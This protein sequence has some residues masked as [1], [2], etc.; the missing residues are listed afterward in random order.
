MTWINW[1]AL[2]S[3]LIAVIG[4]RKLA[5]TDPITQILV[6][7]TAIALPVVVLE[8]L[9]FKRFARLRYRR[10]PFDV[11]L[12]RVSIK[13]AGLAASFGLLVVTYWVFPY[14]T[15]GDSKLV[16]DL[17]GRI[18]IPL[19]ILTPIYFWFVDG[20]MDDPEDD[21]HA[22][23]LFALG[24]LPESDQPKLANHVRACFVKIFFYQYILSVTLVHLTGM[25]SY[26][27][28]AT[29]SVAPFGFMNLFIDTVWF[30]D[31][32]F[33]CTGY[34]LTFRLFNSH[35]R[36]A[37]PTVLG[38]LVCLICY[39]T[40]YEMLTRSFLAYE[41][42]I[43]WG[44]WLGDMPALQ[45]LWAIPI[46][47]LL[48]VYALGSVQFGIRFSNLTHRGIITNGPFRLTKHPQYISKNI[49]FWFISVPFIS[50][51]GPEEAIRHCVMLAGFNFIFYLRAKTEERHLSRDPVYRAYA[52][53]IAQ[54]GLIARARRLMGFA[55]AA[56]VVPLTTTASNHPLP[57]GV[58][59][60]P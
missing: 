52:A 46:V 53:W 9:H 23:G 18:W 40:F 55:T 7:I 21:Y 59:K 6:I 44:H 35:I 13:L 17:F 14:F 58:E 56:Y 43:Y 22:A 16:Y 37:E 41:N 47:V 31:V 51:S 49:A 29:V 34:F 19:V 1:I 42:G 39:G 20:L 5:I 27:P 10:D 28:L 12:K 45:A 26:D 2:A 3:L 8:G 60:G 57:R 25:M 50:A 15:F 30:V 4:L 32:A 33:S 11:R 24:L 38:W 36:S 48:T 54:H